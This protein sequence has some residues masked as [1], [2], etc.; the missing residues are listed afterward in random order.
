MTG[1]GGKLELRSERALAYL[2]NDSLLLSTEL[3]LLL[4]DLLWSDLFIYFL[5]VLLPILQ[6]VPSKQPN[7]GV[8]HSK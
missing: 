6:K 4:G 8:F 1:E 3:N 2:P 7:L 5:Y